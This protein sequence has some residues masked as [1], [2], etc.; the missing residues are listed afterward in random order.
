VGSARLGKVPSAR[1]CVPRV[2]DQVVGRP[3]LLHALAGLAARSSGQSSV[4]LVEAPAG[5]GK[6]TLLAT[7]AH[8][9]RAAGCAVAW[10]ACM[11][12]EDTSTIWPALI[13][14]LRS[15]LDPSGAQRARDALAELEPPGAQTDR[16][17]IGPF[18]ACIDLL[19]PGTVLALDDIH[20][21][22]DPT[23][24][25]GL[26]QLIDQAPNGVHFVLGCRRD[27]GLGVARWRVSDRLREIHVADLT[28]TP[29]EAEEFWR[30]R[31]VTVGDA[32]AAD[33]LART[34]GW[35]AGMQL[36]ALSM[37]S[38]NDPG[39]FVA[40]F[41][42]ND[43]AVE[44]YLTAEVLARV[45]QTWREFMLC[46]S[47]VDSVCG[48]LANCL[49][50]R[51]DGGAM[52]GELERRN[53]LVVR[54]GPAGRWFRYH[55]LLS[56]HLRAEL[57]RRSPARMAELTRV[58]ARWHRDQGRY[59]DA[60]DLAA[61]ANDAPLTAELLRDHGLSLLL[62][63]AQG[64]VRRATANTSGGLASTPVLLVHQA[65]AAL[66]VGDLPGADAALDGIDRRAV[67]RA[68]DQRLSAL[69]DLAQLQRSRLAADLGTAS[70]NDLLV[71]RLDLDPSPDDHRPVLDQDI[72]L[73]ALAN[74]GALRLFAG[75]HLGA[76]DDLTRAAHLARSAGLN[77]LG[78]YCLSLL[79]GSYM[80]ANQF[81]LTRRSAEEAIAFASRRG[82]QRS[83]RLAYPYALAAWTASLMLDPQIAAARAADALDVLDATV[84]AEAEG[85][86]RSGEAII[87]FDDP[88]Q[89]RAALHRL[90]ET[91]E[92][93]TPIDV[94]PPLIAV[95]AEHEVRM[96]LALGLWDMA[97][98]AAQRTIQ[99][100]GEV[101]D[102][103]VMRG[104]LAYHRGRDA[105]ARRHLGPVLAG[106]LVP[107]S[108]TATTTAWLL[109][110]LIAHRAQ[111]PVGVDRAL[112]AS[113]AH[114]SATQAVRPFFDAGAEIR[115]L[116]GGLR[117]R[118][119]H[120]ERLLNS[121]FNGLTRMD[122]W[123]ARARPAGTGGLDGPPLSPR[124][125]QVLH[126]LPSMRTLAEIAATQSVSANTVKTH[127]RSIYS[128]LGVGSR[129][130][131]I[132]AARAR[133]LL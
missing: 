65:L 92:W 48:D 116:L 71:G 93:L 37:S 54:L 119:G 88:K 67:E 58:A 42:A 112:R 17:F 132:A 32:L 59:G 79:P 103:A 124:E 106:E 130:E 33:L 73:V 1:V 104:K 50:G 76:R 19:P 94:S 102:I 113:L 107:I 83:A 101:G 109:E 40:D 63:G 84:D 15:A 125:L 30:R 43:R 129:R 47:V 81:A 126:E 28:F 69:H 34:E 20:H 26:T 60:L 3:R 9:L 133:D 56:R 121:V 44:D 49:T 111:A 66:E 12:N 18:L 5:Y 10:V 123:Q 13:S 39:D 36:A 98:R 78:L 6:T 127:V 122:A 117:G 120:E 23:A 74:R 90:L 99:R 86:A 45:P 57:E 110:A 77:H 2:G 62:A 24:L 27:P 7:A 95:P 131:A 114:A 82:W 29:D 96:C 11:P 41:L 100:L 14:S 75:D 128:K 52:L 21:L 68:G 31:G 85:A 55:S 89:R 105:E 115:P 25:A 4:V 91:T 38:T 72:R 16:D 108:A 35:A 118:A 70:D 80:A 97:E 61:R 22:Q 53:L 51:D 64:P 8:E 46:T 87:S